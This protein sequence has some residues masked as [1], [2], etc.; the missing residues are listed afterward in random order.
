MDNN[1][2]NN[3]NNLNEQNNDIV[4]INNE[5][6]ENT[7]Q[8]SNET[9]SS[10]LEKKIP[11]NSIVSFI[12]A[13]KKIF[14]VIFLVLI[15]SISGIILF[16]NFYDFSKIK[17]IDKENYTDVLTSSI[18][19][20]S[21]E[22]ED[23]DGN[24]IN[25]IS[26]SVE[27]GKI[28]SEKTKVKW[29]LP[30]KKGKYTIVAKT[31][32]GKKITKEINV[33]D[34]S[35]NKMLALDYEKNDIVDNDDIKDSDY[36]G[37]PDKYEIN[38][39][40]TDPKKNDTDGDGITDGDELLLGLDPLK[41]DSKGDGIKDGDRTL[42]YNELFYDDK[43]DVSVTGKGNIASLTVDVFENNALKNV[44]G[45]I[46]RVYNFYDDGT[47]DSSTV[48][49]SYD[50]S[51]IEEYGYNEDSLSLFYFNEKTKEFEKVEST[52]DKDNKK[53]IA[54]LKHFSK[55]LLADYE[56]MMDDQKINVMFVIDNSISMYSEEQ[57][58]SYGY[59]D[60]IGADGNDKDFKRF[61]LT[62]SMIDRFEGN[63]NFSI[64]EF[65]GDYN[66]LLSFSSDKAVAKKNVDSMMGNWNT[67][68]D[69]T[70][71]VNALE[72]GINDFENGVNNYLII[73]T[74]GKNT[75]GNLSNKK[76]SII[77]EAKNKNI[78]ICS[79]GLGNVDNSE[80]DEISTETGCAHYNVGDSSS[81]DEIYSIIGSTIDWGMVDTDYD[82]RIDSTVIKDSGFVVNRDG[83]SFPNFSSVQSPGGHCYGMALFA[84][85]RYK[86]LL[87]EKLDDISVEYRRITTKKLEAK[88]YDLSNTYFTGSGN[89]YDFKFS[90][91]TLNNFFYR[92]LWPSD[93]YKEPALN[94]VARLI[95]D[96]Y[97]E[98][99]INNGLLTNLLEC[100]SKYKTIHSCEIVNKIDIYSDKLSSNTKKDD[101]Q[102]L[103]AIYRL[104][105]IQL[106]KEKQSIATHPDDVFEKMSYAINQHNPIVIGIGNSK[107][108]SEHAV[109]AIRLIQSNDNPN[110]IKIQI[111]DNKYPGKYKYI[112]LTRHK[113]KFIGD[114]SFES[115]IN[116]Y[117]YDVAYDWNNDGK[118]SK[119][120]K[121]NVLYYFDPDSYIVTVE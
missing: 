117:S 35:E 109:N 104:F 39:F 53:V 7:N 22:A 23:K 96:E 100:D 50:L 116:D 93:F 26:F 114:F 63:Y 2:N 31:P 11:L 92:N 10:R 98:K 38:E 106:T 81:L 29:T 91:D 14:L 79:I 112:Y 27:S 28:E 84:Y 12:K 71:I 18:L 40:K 115:I 33:V 64:S 49:I 80:L 58:I 46:P 4:E 103:Q 120:E 59:N 44:K 119:N 110:D 111:Y 88:G 61:L 48:K 42:T 41:E 118:I 86:D 76:N 94:D 101:Y 75:T 68:A 66:N 9:L 85:L 78:K 16:Y 25:D 21:V 55:Y 89:L 69:G 13:K 15:V 57:M 90:N 30:D 95:K 34:G 77:D 108:N 51:E 62:K 17:W 65:S 47:I 102:L 82:N 36:D 113:S 74:D 67:D 99:I 70:N 60:S 83:F 37:I 3:D 19:E 5:I 52:I 8:V 56:K 20:L 73:M 72:S 97:R 45:V 107:K 6:I 24:K 43:V 105:V 54:T 121:E 1:P 32:S 87:P